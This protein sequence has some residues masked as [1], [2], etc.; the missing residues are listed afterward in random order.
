MRPALGEAYTNYDQALD[1][2]LELGNNESR[3]ELVRRL[4]SRMDGREYHRVS[5]MGLDSP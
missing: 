4:S 5:A 1:E 2:V 3:L